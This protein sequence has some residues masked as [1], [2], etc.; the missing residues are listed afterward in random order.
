MEDVRTTIKVNARTLGRLDEFIRICQRL[1][2]EAEGLNPRIFCGE[3]I[4][5]EMPKKDVDFTS[6]F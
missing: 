2:A 1:S 4:P 3:S 6:A 5:Q